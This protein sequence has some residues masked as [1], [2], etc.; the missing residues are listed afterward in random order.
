MVAFVRPAV[1]ADM[2]ALVELA[3]CLA[4][5][6]N[7]HELHTISPERVK[8]TVSVFFTP[9]YVCFLLFVDGVLCGF[10][11]GHMDH[12]PFSFDRVAYEDFFYVHPA[13]R[14]QFY[15]CRLVNTFLNWAQAEG[16]MLVRMRVESGIT[17]ERTVKLLQHFG[18][19]PA[20]TALLRA[21]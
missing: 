9:D 8:E 18:F 2:D 20:G 4:H 14:G 11:A 6:G 10:I 21:L 1:H 17:E 13:Y 7:I 5:E 3:Q 15:F 16:A 12:P 19:S